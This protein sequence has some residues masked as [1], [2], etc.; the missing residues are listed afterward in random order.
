MDR[1]HVATLNIRNLA[2]RW[3]ERLPLLLADMAALQPDLLGMQEVVYVL[4]QDR[5]IGAAG[6]GRYEA[7]RAWAGRPE[8]GNSL[9][10]RTP[11]AGRSTDR[12][13]LG[14]NRSALRTV[15]ELAGGSTVL[16]VVT[17]LHHEV[18]DEAIRD[19]QA[20]QLLAWLETAP[21]DRYPDRDGRLQRRAG[22][23]D[24][25]PDGRRRLSIGAGRGQ[26]R[27]AGRDV[28]V[29]SAGARA[30]TRTASRAASTT[31]G[32]SARRG[33]SMRGRVRSPGGRRSDAA[34]QRSLRPQRAPRDRLTV[35]RSRRTLRLA[36]RGDWRTAPENTLPAL[37]AACA[38]PACDGLE[39]DVRLSADGVPILL[40]DATLAR[41]QG[42][43]EA[44]GALSASDLAALGVPAL[45]DVLAAV[46]RRA[47]LDVELKGDP[48]RAVVEVLAAGRGA[49][50]RDAVVSSFDTGALERVGGLAPT[51]PRWLNTHDLRARDDLV[52]AGA[53]VH[54][55]RG[56]L[57]GHRRRVQRGAVRA[58]GLELAAYTVRR[59]STFDRL[60]RLGVVAVCVEAAALDGP[61]PAA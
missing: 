46:P 8:Y 44:P 52:G 60:A 33:S 26:W 28:A 12:L 19:D 25:C 47:F 37:L 20:R 32:S 27:G 39:F 30:W 5:L 50:L 13:E 53:A 21:G 43:P 54:G 7:L 15:V 38:I 51:W 24:L 59:R 57:A 55:H 3:D 11:L 48:G 10:V 34:A 58:A 56:R 18:P 49:D 16:V 31:C 17:H 2:D 61:T 22:R 4:Q 6:E 14:H 29:R 1:L 41:V 40:H 9:L 45:A 23:A 42:R 36:H 35:A